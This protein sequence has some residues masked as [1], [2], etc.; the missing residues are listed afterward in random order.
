MAENLHLA[1]HKKLSNKTASKWRDKWD[2]ILSQKKD[3]DCLNYAGRWQKVII[4]TDSIHSG[5]YIFSNVPCKFTTH[6]MQ[7]EKKENPQS[8][9]KNC[10]N[11]T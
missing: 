10:I 9:R 7:T 2:P 5:A 1:N 11:M 8:T 6:C 3:F 4:H